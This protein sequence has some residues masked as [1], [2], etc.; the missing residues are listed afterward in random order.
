MTLTMR[1]PELLAKHGTHNQKTHGRRGVRSIRGAPFRVP[2]IRPV[3]FLAKQLGQRNYHDVVVDMDVHAQRA[4]AYQALP[5]MDRKALP[6]FRA[7]RKEMLKQYTLLTKTLGVE[8]EFVDE[9]PYPSVV[10]LAAD[11]RR[12]KMRVYRTDNNSSHP[13]LTNDENDKFRAVHDAFGHA[14]TGRGFDRHGEEAAYLAHASMFSPLATKALATETRGQNSVVIMYGVFAEQKVALLPDELIKAARRTAPAKVKEPDPDIDNLYAKSGVHHIS[15]GRYGR[16]KVGKKTP[17]DADADRL[18]YDGTPRE[19]PAPPKGAKAPAKERRL[20]SGRKPVQRRKPT[21]AKPETRAPNEDTMMLHQD[22]RGNWSPERVKLHDAIIEDMLQGHEPSDE[23]MAL[24]LGGGPASGKST[25][26]PTIDVPDGVTIDS[27]HI[28]GYLPEYQEMVKSKDRTAAAYA[29]EE[30]SYLGKAVTARALGDGLNVILDGTGDSSIEKLHKKVAEARESGHGVRAVYVTVDT[31]TAVQR[32]NSR[33]EQTGRLVPEAVVREIHASVTDTFVKAIEEDLFD[34]VDLWDTNSEGGAV[35]VGRKPE[36]GQWTVTN[37]DAWERFLAKSPNQTIE[38]A[39]QMD[40]GEAAIKILKAVTLG[41]SMEDARIPEDL[42]D[43]WDEIAEQVEAM[44]DEYVVQIPS[45]YNAE[46][47]DHAE[48]PEPP[49]EKPVLDKSF[50]RFPGLVEKVS[51]RAY[52]SLERRPGKQNWVDHA[53]GLPDYI[54]RIAKHLHYEKG[55]SIGHAIATAVN[56]CRKWAAGKG[57]VNADTKAKAAKA[58][59]Q[60]EAKKVKSKAKKTA[61]LK[62]EGTVMKFDEEKRLVFGWAYVTHDPTGTLNVDKSGEFVDDPYEV[63]EAAYGFVLKS[64]TGDVDHTNVETSTLV[65]SIMFTPE[66]IEKMGL[67]DGIIPTGWWVGFK[68]HDDT[69]WKNRHKYT[70]F[71]I[72]GSASKEAT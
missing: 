3:G 7:F 21:Q 58:I 47:D 13:F 31:E 49:K 50:M 33:G 18:I 35:L 2:R 52:P 41:Q 59:A 30:S 28:K 65:E 16:G 22:G 64:R 15:N 55:M 9:D 12:K 53:G 8:V 66:K 32:S 17:R 26:L 45:D 46:S 1:H 24:F 61:P 23:P 37:D 56:Q 29:H 10:E 68:V 36:G 19:R 5:S 25:I 11:L 62:A 67:P 40:R 43:L 57:N 4:E 38:K 44:G 63:E 54:E 69:V 34:S 6:A 27:D 42:Q 72:F 14:A 39:E 48:A 71:S 70:S 20:P 51:S 60:W